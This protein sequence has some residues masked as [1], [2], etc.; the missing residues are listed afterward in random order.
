MSMADVRFLEEIKDLSGKRVLL[1]VDFNVPL[2]KNEDGEIEV[3]DD[4]RIVAALPTIEYLVDKGA[5]VIILSH[6]G[7][8]KGKRVEEL[9]LLPVAKHLAQLMR[10]AVMFAPEAIGEAA[11]M[12]VKGL[13][14]GDVLILENVRF[15]PGEEKN[16]PEFARKLA[17]YGDVFVS[18]AFSVAHRAHASNVGVATYLKAYAGYLM[19]KEIEHL[20]MLLDPKD[21]PYYVLLGGAKVSDK[22]GVIN[23]LLDKVD[24]L[25][26]GGGMAF[27]FLKALGKDIGRSLVEED[28]IDY[29]AEVMEKAKNLGKKFVL[30]VDVVVGDSPDAN[31]AS[32]TSVD[33]IPA[34]KMGLD[35][36][37]ESVELFK[38]EMADGRLFFWNGPM[39]VFENPLFAK[40]TEELAHY[41]AELCQNGAK[42][43]I[44]GGDSAAAVKKFEDPKRFTHISTGG[45][46]SLKFVEGKKLP[47]I[48]VLK[49]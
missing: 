5:K 48:E 24:G 18:D 7:R 14:P 10:R 27:T 12:A 1:R 23:N 26:I 21:R 44:G 2:K 43:V 25:F 17:S 35:I 49:W 34:D 4:T 42:V 16:D 38:R 39:G 3:A 15:Y 19:I 8:P 36:G 6:L 22:I 33:A 29:A 37:P 46:A 41:L 11:E 40:G 45:G 30:P 20:G 28:Y 13:E 9:S 32:V 47:G 31:E